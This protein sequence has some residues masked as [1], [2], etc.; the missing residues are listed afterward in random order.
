MYLAGQAAPGS[1]DGLRGVAPASA[2]AVGMHPHIG[3]VDGIRLTVMVLRQPSEHL[4]PH[5][6]LHPTPPAGVN[7][8]PVGKLARQVPPGAARARNPQ[9]GLHKWPILRPRS[10]LA[11]A[12]GAFTQRRVNFFR[13]NQR[14]PSNLRGIIATPLHGRP[15]AVPLIYQFGAIISVSANPGGGN[16]NFVSNVDSKSMA[17]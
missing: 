2:G 13:P 4:G 5:P 1:A 6:A 12:A 8:A 9:H 7:A 14:A 15:Q 3:R 10:A 11:L 17:H 16:V